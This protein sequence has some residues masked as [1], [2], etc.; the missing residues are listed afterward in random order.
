M[1]N[2]ASELTRRGAWHKSEGGLWRGLGCVR[3]KRA[4]RNDRLCYANC[5]LFVSCSNPITGELIFSLDST[6]S[7]IRKKRK[8]SH[9]QESVVVEGP[10][11]FTTGVVKWKFSCCFIHLARKH[12]LRR[13]EKQCFDST[14]LRVYLNMACAKI[15]PITCEE[16]FDK[17]ME[18]HYRIIVLD[19]HAAWC[20]PCTVMKIF[21]DKLML[22]IERCDERVAWWSVNQE[23]YPELIKSLL[24]TWSKVNIYTK[25]CCP[26]FL[27]IQY[28]PETQVMEMVAEVIGCDS[29]QA[30]K[31]I[32]EYIPPVP[33]TPR[34]PWRVLRPI[35]TT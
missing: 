19:V 16:D 20:G 1:G 12:H 33:E 34:S 25:G 23:E 18:D 10:K 21:W 31:E 29:P 7:S 22:D 2:V 28:N 9:E 8:S 30:I 5:Q 35:L 15:I 13:I 17:M 26:L 32:K 11:I 24:P 6:H 14:Y 27:F 4:I 3:G